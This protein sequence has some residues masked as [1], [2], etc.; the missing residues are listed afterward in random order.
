MMFQNNNVQ[1]GS[2]I[3]S[4]AMQRRMDMMLQN[5]N[6][7]FSLGWLRKRLWNELGSRISEVPATEFYNYSRVLQ[8]SYE[9]RFMWEFLSACQKS[10]SDIK[11]IIDNAYDGND[12]IDELMEDR[13]ELIRE[14]ARMPLS[15]TWECVKDDDQS[16]R[17]F[18]RRMPLNGPGKRQG[19]ARFFETL[20]RISIITDIACRRADEYG[21]DVDYSS[22]ETDD[23]EQRR[24]RLTDEVLVRAIESVSYHLVS[25]SAWVVVYCVLRD[26]YGYQNQSQ[27][28]R[29]V[30][31]LPFK[32]R[33]KDCPE[34]T[35]SKTMSNHNYLYSPID[36]WPPDSKFT[37]FACDLRA[38]V[39]SELYK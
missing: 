4:Q 11:R 21:L 6:T 7:L 36:K 10:L 29:D 28:E 13:E 33:L 39:K 3:F 20:D 5:A 31:Q 2:D 18:A 1:S 34:G 15:K 23:L 38:A 16:W 9:S 30:I 24:A 26:D 22:M 8:G 25:Y 32:K 17:N 35:V 12:P 27:F 19:V 37:K 14:F